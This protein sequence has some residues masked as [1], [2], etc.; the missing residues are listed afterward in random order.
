MKNC[1][2]CGNEFEPKRATAQYC[3]TKCRVYASRNTI[4]KAVSV[5]ENLSVTPVSVTNELSVTDHQCKRCKA[6]VSELIC[7]CYECVTKHNAKHDDY[8]D[9]IT[10]KFSQVP[11]ELR[12][13]ID[14]RS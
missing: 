11:E 2:V 8:C 1:T 13:T 10:S 3:S 6:P 5:T 12:I 4:D 14:K 9:C 7:I